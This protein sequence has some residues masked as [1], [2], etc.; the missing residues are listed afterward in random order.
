M[1][2]S[3]KL[4]YLAELPG[5]QSV[6]VK[7]SAVQ[8]RKHPAALTT[9]ALNKTSPA[10]RGASHCSRFRNHHS[11]LANRLHLEV[12]VLFYDPLLLL[13]EMSSAESAI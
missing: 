1:V 12:R 9:A 11:Y 6:Y 5:G 10:N 7:E 13:P 4:I 2:I 3:D 8:T